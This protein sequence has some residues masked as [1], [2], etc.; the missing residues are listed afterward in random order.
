[1]GNNE[2][3]ARPAKR[4]TRRK[5]EPVDIDRVLAAIGPI[6]PRRDI[7]VARLAPKRLQAAVLLG[8]PH[9]QYC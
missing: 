9:M 2:P 4:Q 6:I 3:H 8:S 1:M 5:P 7:T